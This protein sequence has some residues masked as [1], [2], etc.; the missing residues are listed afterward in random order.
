[1]RT[2][3]TLAAVGLAFSLC[4]CG[5]ILQ[6]AYQLESHQRQANA[7][8]GRLP[9]QPEWSL[10]L[11]HGSNVVEYF[12]ADGHTVPLQEARWGDPRTDVSPFLVVKHGLNLHVVDLRRQRVLHSVPRPEGWYLHGAID[13]TGVRAALLYFDARIPEVRIYDVPR[14]YAPILALKPPAG[15]STHDLLVWC[16]ARRLCV[17]AGNGKSWLC[18]TTTGATRE[19]EGRIYALAPDGRLCGEDAGGLFLLD[20]TT[21]EKT[22][23]PLRPSDI[24][25][26][27]Y[28]AAFITDDIFATR[29]VTEDWFF[30][31]PITDTYLVVAE[32]STGRLTRV[33]YPEDGGAIATCPWK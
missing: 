19:L 9:L 20:L 4:G 22:R 25:S 23:T 2:I 26:L 21:M 6:S 17:G 33:R 32:F 1:M 12:P 15:S 8:G 16:D 18:D 11:V 10:L 14:N 13:P 5:P 29:Y 30:D 27:R 28:G 31:L 24:G 3:S 7:P